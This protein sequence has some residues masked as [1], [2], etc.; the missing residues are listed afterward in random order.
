MGQPNDPLTPQEWL[1][2]VQSAVVT[3]GHASEVTAGLELTQQGWK[4]F[5]T[6]VLTAG[7]NS[8]AGAA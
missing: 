1:A 4:V 6:P 3:S 5:L 8:P 7:D 2:V